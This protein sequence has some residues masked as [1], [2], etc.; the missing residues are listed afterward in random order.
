MRRSGTFAA[1]SQPKEGGPRWL[2]LGEGTPAATTNG[3]SIAGRWA[4]DGHMIADPPVS[5]SGFDTY[6]VLAGGYFLVHHV[7]VQVGDQSVRAIEIIGELDPSSDGFLA[8][9][10]RQHGEL[11]SHAGDGR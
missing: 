2:P 10:V 8:R 4:T 3:W 1:T 5:V 6:E 7:D 11:G 9:I